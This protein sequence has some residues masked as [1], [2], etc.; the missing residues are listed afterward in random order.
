VKLGMSPVVGLA[1]LSLCAACSRQ[2]PTDSPQSI[3]PASAPVASATAP[4]PAM[5]ADEANLLKLIAAVDANA[6]DEAAF[7][8]FCD[9]FE[10]TPDFTG[11]TGRVADVQ[12][13]TVNGAIDV[14][15]SMGKHLRIEPV[16]EKTDPLYPAVDALTV[17]DAVTLSGHFSHNA[18]SSECTYYLGSFAVS[19]T[20]VK[21]G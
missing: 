6:K 20:K 10:K 21:A 7:N 15:F 4:V 14:T 11:W 5:P 13:S 3:P 9:A 8:R 17:G 18:G 12:T 1:V 19:L 16:V 2:A